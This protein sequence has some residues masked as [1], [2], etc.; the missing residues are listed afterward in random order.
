MRIVVT[1]DDGIASPGIWALARALDER[2]HDV[3]VVAPHED[4]S[5][6]GAAIGRIRPDQ[7]IDTSPGKFRVAPPKLCPQQHIC[8]G[9]VD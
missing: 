7:R 9:L 5:G 3:C 8:R 6:V 4:M 1:N 2:G